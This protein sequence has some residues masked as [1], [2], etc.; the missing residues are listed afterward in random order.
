MAA[1]GCISGTGPPPYN[2]LYLHLIE[3]KMYLKT[4]VFYD[5]SPC[6]LVNSY[7]AFE[8][9]HCICL[10][11]VDKVDTHNNPKDLTVLQLCLEDFRSCIKLCSQQPQ[12]HSLTSDTKVLH[13]P[14][15]LQ[16]IYGFVLCFTGG[17]MVTCQAR[18]R[19]SWYLKRER[20]G[21]SWF[22][23]PRANL[24]TM[25]CLSAQMTGSHMLWYAVRYKSLLNTCVFSA[26]R[27]NN[28]D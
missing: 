9:L 25:S 4:E 11:Q 6:W 14:V 10:C 17:F 18:R 15:P 1:F 16:N 24:E 19:R 27:G 7:W 12:D 22:E 23:S 2:V 28:I 8:G 20:M 26:L 5:I 13:H 3:T 21:V